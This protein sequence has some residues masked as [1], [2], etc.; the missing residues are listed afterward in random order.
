MKRRMDTLIRS[1]QQI[2]RHLEQWVHWSRTRADCGCCPSYQPAPQST[3]AL[4]LL[5]S[6]AP[7]ANPKRGDWL[8]RQGVMD[9]LQI[10]Y[11][12]YYRFK[13]EGI[14]KPHRIGQR[15]YYF[16]QDLQ[17]VFLES[18]RKGRV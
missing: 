9:Y 10:S 13:A 18:V 4:S 8:D 7:S 2:E 6:F 17:T 1:V 16:R 14:L 12:T 3:Q 11:R 15:D 5:Q